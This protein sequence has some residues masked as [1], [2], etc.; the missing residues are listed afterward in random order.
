MDFED[1]RKVHRAEK[2][3]EEIIK[4]QQNFYSEAAK[5]LETVSGKEKEQVLKMLNEIFEK[6]EQKIII[7][8]L[9]DFKTG[10]ISE[11]LVDFEK[12]FYDKI[13]LALK[14]NRI[15]FEKA[16]YGL[17]ESKSLNNVKVQ[18]LKKIPKIL[19]SDSK[20]YGPFEENQIVELPKDLVDKLVKEGYL[21]II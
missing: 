18:I 3:S 19:W 5:F 17:K 1:I 13:M 6:R 11:I 2:N 10:S 15:S 7:K 21:K 20:E 8:A 14:E 12:Q 4:L 16:I 9:K